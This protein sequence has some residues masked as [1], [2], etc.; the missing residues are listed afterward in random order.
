M[1]IYHVADASY[2]IALYRLNFLNSFFRDKQ[3]LITER[4]YRELV[5]NP[6]KVLYSIQNESLKAKI[7]E[8]ISV[9]KK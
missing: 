7:L 1:T 4:I 5:E 6:K 2:P 9:F 8:S 3:V